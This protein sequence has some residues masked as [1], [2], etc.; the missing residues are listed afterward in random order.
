MTVSPSTI[1]TTEDFTVNVTVRNSGQ[2]DGKEVVQ[3]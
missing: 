3:V 1:S 2:V